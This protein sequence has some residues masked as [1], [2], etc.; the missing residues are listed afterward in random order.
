MYVY[1]NLNERDLLR[2]MELQRAERSA[3]GKDREP[4][5]PLYLGLANEEG[6]PHEG[7]YD[8]AESSVD[9]ETGTMQ[10]RGVFDNPG[11][12]PK[13]VPGLFA[14]VRLPLGKRPGMP[15]VSERA[16]GNDQGGSYVL[17][18]NAENVVE[19][20]TVRT[21][22]RID[23]LIVIEDGLRK[24]DRVIVKGVQRGRPGRT[25]DPDQVDMASLTTS[26]LKQAAEQAEAAAKA[27]HRGAEG[28][29]QHP[30]GEE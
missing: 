24:N 13:I 3:P 15:L 9:A 14:R 17:V 29:A 6:Y 20:R 27:K 30:A 26:A 4:D 23:G 18:V 11:T 28:D 5:I 2:V 12:P 16:V 25:V 8:F 1:F 7:R 21:G 22:Q 19:R 10:L